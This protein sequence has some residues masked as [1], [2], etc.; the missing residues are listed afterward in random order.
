ME[1]HLIIRLATIPSD[2][3]AD[4]AEIETPGGAK[5]A[6][7]SSERI[8]SI[9]NTKLFRRTI[10]FESQHALSSYHTAACS[11]SAGLRLHAARGGKPI[12][13]A[14]RPIDRYN[15]FYHHRK[16]DLFSRGTRSASRILTMVFDRTIG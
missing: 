11:I 1:P 15:S 4:P 6:S 7:R 9:Q 12:F 3:Q 2:D 10:A 13:G 16:E 8:S 14:A 5:A